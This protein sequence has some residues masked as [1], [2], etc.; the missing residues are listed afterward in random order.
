[1]MLV[2]KQRTKKQTN[3]NNDF[4]TSRTVFLDHQLRNKSEFLDL[5]SPNS[6]ETGFLKNNMNA[7]SKFGFLKNIEFLFY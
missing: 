5:F 2:P 1:M 6:E 3:L 7:D 4:K